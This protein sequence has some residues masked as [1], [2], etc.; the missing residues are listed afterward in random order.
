MNNLV[1]SDFSWW[2]DVY[3]PVW[4][5]I[6]S[7][8]PPGTNV[9]ERDWDLLVILDAC[10]VDALRSQSDS[11]PWI[12]DVDSIRSVG[13]MSGEWILK[14][15]SQK[16][17]EEIRETAF[18]SQN[19]WSER[20]LKHDLHELQ[21]HEYEMLYRGRP[22][23]APVSASTFA[24]YEFLAPN[25]GQYDRIH[26]EGGGIPNVVVD[27]AI[28]VARERR[29]DRLIVHLLP[30]HLPHYADAIDWE[31][32]ERSVEELMA[33]PEP[34]RELRPHEKSY[35]PA[36]D[37]DVAI[38]TIR[39]TYLKHLRF[40]LEYVEILLDNVDA[41]K[42]VIS[43]DHGEGFGERGIWAHPYGFPLSPIKTVP[44]ATGVATDRKGYEPQYEPMNRELTQE[45]QLDHF[46]DLG[47]L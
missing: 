2:H 32:G 6:T 21:G 27:R 18:I 23:W 36:R 44:W 1:D 17:R 11:I 42:V 16:Y 38:E 26:P 24:H 7:R 29:F 10:R 33:G 9:F 40:G 5:T 41:E 31:P 12:A 43:A 25:T 20:I 15:F 46:R 19:I 3:I 37:G 22:R 30:P 34:T 45:E 28:S 39:E 4:N 13:S 8:Y 47:Y 35:E 14:T